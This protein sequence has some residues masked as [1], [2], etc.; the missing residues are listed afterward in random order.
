MTHRTSTPCPRCSGTG[1]LAQYAHVAGGR[2]F[3]CGRSLGAA[4]SVR[5]PEQVRASAEGELLGYLAG[6]RRA[7]SEGYLADWEDPGEDFPPTAGVVGR[8]LR[9]SGEEHRARMIAAFKAL[10]LSA[11]WWSRARDSWRRAA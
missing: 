4:P 11:E 9:E 3:R 10:P 5:T 6:A 8:C 2:C 7:E 1:H